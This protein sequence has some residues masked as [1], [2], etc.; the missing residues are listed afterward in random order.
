MGTGTVLTTLRN[1]QM[2]PISQSVTGTD[3]GLNQ[4][5]PRKSSVVNTTS[6]VLG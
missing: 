4:K 5:L 2:G 1:S 3:Q 6:G